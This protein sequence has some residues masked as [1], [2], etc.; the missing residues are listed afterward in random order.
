MHLRSKFDLSWSKVQLGL[1]ARP[2]LGMMNMKL[3]AVFD[4]LEHIHVEIGVPHTN[5]KMESVLFD[6][7]GR[8]FAHALH[9]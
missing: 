2:E 8:V 9:L 1:S 3:Q 7:G 4:A 5:I 6:R